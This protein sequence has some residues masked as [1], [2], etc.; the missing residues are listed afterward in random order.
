MPSPNVKRRNRVYVWFEGVTLSIGM[1]LMATIIERRV[2]RA[3]KQG[4]A[5]AAPRTAAGGEEP[6]TETAA[7]HHI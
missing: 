2:L 3:L 5:V 4:K 1:S 7:V 6:P